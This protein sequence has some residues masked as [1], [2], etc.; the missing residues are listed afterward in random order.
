MRPN[1]ITTLFEYNAWAFERVWE[2]ICQL[3][4][5]QFV[6]EIDYSTGSIRNITVHMLS[7]ADRWKSRLQGTPLPPHLAFEAFDTLSKAKAKWDA[8][9]AEFLAYVRCL[10]Q[11]QLD[12]MVH[13]ELP[14]RG[15]ALESP[16]WEILLH[17]ANHATDHR[18]QILAT[19]H[20][21]FHVKTVEQDLILYLAEQR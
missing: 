12:A 5:A 3:S 10:S 15:L 20:Q 21:H 9:Q 13:W 1:E 4:E 16:C 19:L 2:C 18:A 11:E 14:A 17:V 8:L 7:A 6:E